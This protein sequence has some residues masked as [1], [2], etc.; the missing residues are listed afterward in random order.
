MNIDVVVGLW[1]KNKGHY[2]HDDH[3]SIIT[4]IQDVPGLNILS[5]GSHVGHQVVVQEFPLPA[6]GA[7]V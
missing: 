7:C 5:L 4:I 3:V 6:F 1:C 2:Y